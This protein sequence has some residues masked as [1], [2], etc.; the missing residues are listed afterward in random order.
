MVQC[1]CSRGVIEKETE[2]VQVWFKK[3]RVGSDSAFHIPKEGGGNWEVLP[4][5]TGDLVEV[6]RV[7]KVGEIPWISHRCLG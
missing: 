5:R 4:R 2:G 1:R 7:I 6:V 3:L